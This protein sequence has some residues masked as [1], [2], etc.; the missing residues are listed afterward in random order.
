VLRFP[1]VLLR[2]AAALDRCSTF[3]LFMLGFLLDTLLKTAFGPK[4]EPTILIAGR[5]CWNM[6]KNCWTFPIMDMIPSKP[7]TR[8]NIDLSP[9]DIGA[10]R[11]SSAVLKSFK[12]S[13]AAGKIA[14]V[15]AFFILFT[16]DH[17]PFSIIMKNCF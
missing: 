12:G 7:P 15:R 13:L 17:F 3:L 8:A 16:S 10:A 1:F 2:E 14:L 9:T 6:P 5:I 11:E 4:N